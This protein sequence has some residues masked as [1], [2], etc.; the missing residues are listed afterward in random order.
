M[1]PTQASA[2]RE[3]ERFA[4]ASPEGQG[5]SIIS[6]FFKKPRLGVQVR[7]MLSEAE[8]ALRKKKAKTARAVPAPAVLLAIGDGLPVVADVD[9]GE[10]IP[11]GDAASSSSSEGKPERDQKEGEDPASAAVAPSSCSSA[12]AA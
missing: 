5:R 2:R 1:E 12:G 3:F 6:Y 7:K 9:D 4:K 8:T 10:G 11:R